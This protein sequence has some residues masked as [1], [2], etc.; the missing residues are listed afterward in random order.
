[1]FC[2]CSGKEQRKSRRVNNKNGRQFN[3]F[4]LSHTQ[5]PRQHMLKASFRP[6]EHCAITIL[7]DTFRFTPFDTFHFAST[8]DILHF[9]RST[10]VALYFWSRGGRLHRST[11]AQ[12]TSS[13]T[14]RQHRAKSCLPTTPKKHRHQWRRGSI[15][16][17]YRPEQ[18]G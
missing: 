1:M 11:I 18:Q 2:L 7:L 13:Q 17:P 15:H 10:V 12:V 9:R 8:P 4:P 14:T 3:F 5:G 16:P 6:F